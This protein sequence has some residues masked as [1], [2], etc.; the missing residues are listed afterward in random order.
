MSNFIKDNEDELLRLNCLLPNGYHFVLKYEPDSITY[1]GDILVGV[2]NAY[3]NKDEYL[4]YT[5]ATDLRDT[6]REA[7]D[8]FTRLQERKSAVENFN[9]RSKGFS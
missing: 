2:K 8:K 9:E 6:L 7:A 1:G 4:Y 5:W 3:S